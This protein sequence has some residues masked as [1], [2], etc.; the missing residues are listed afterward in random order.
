MKINKVW[1]VINKDVK[2]RLEAIEVE[3]EKLNVLI[4]ALDLISELKNI[5]ELPDCNTCMR[6]GCEYKP[7]LGEYTRFNCPLHMSSAV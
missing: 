6:Q 7:K 2:A 1:D 4:Q 3:Q 5:E